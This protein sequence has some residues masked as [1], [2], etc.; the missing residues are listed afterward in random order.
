MGRRKS[1]AKKPVKE[2]EAVAA[3]GSDAE[4][5]DGEW[6]T[7][8]GKDAFIKSH[9]RTNTGT[10]LHWEAK[11]G[12]IR[13]SWPPSGPGSE[14]VVVYES[15]FE[16]DHR[17][18]VREGL[19]LAYDV[20][21][22]PNEK[23]K[24]KTPYQAQNVLVLDRF[25][26]GKKAKEATEAPATPPPS[27]TGA[28]SRPPPVHKQRSSQPSDSAA[29]AA[30]VEPARPREE[31]LFL[32]LD[33]T[34]APATS[35]ESPAPGD[36]GAGGT[37]NVKTTRRGNGNMKMRIEE[38]LRDDLEDDVV[39]ATVKVL[40]REGYTDFQALQE[41]KPSQARW[42]EFGRRAGLPDAVIEHKR[43][44]RMFG[45]NLPD[46]TVTMTS[47]D[48]LDAE[49][50]AWYGGDYDT[51]Y[52]LD[53]YALQALGALVHDT[54]ENAAVGI[55]RDGIIKSHHAN[56]TSYDG[57]LTYGGA[58]DVVFFQGSK[59]GENMSIYPR[60]RKGEQLPKCRFIVPAAVLG[61]H[62][63]KY[64]MYFVSIS[65]S[66]AS[67]AEKKTMLQ[68]HLLFLPTFH[69]LRDFCDQHFLLVNKLT[70]QP[71]HYNREKHNWYGFSPG[72]GK[73]DVFDGRGVM[74][75][76]AVADDIPISPLRD[77]RLQSPEECAQ[78]T[79]FHGGI[80]KAPGQRDDEGMKGMGCVHWLKNGYCDVFKC[81]YD[82]P[83][84]YFYNVESDGSGALK[85]VL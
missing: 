36:E 2:Q 76:V 22:N 74:I 38:A 83:P 33:E 24:V 68:L 61:L 79:K 73:S 28:V 44:A 52:G 32:T 29:A 14:N 1:Q 47:Q 5:G 23:C 72:A 25:K 54:Y 21:P 31:Q 6:E 16:E 39:A 30:A 15:D 13:P 58:P 60:A 77:D 17:E 56:D 20:I 71:F 67:K 11:T 84:W 18:Y 45:P 69:R 50:R 64:S 26:E 53:P 66:R 82:H 57:M 65:E 46:M 51:K 62:T 55:C 80:M 37:E 7:V 27:N 9:N 78:E 43:L 70:F 48:R 12:F 81:S 49:L 35:R 3:T 85:R 75:N 10:F 59:C 4:S 42:R 34:F 19:K 8:E 40:H 41:A 63:T